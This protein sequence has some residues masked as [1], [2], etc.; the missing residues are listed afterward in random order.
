MAV[1][2]R[3][4]QDKGLRPA[5]AVGVRVTVPLTPL[6]TGRRESGDTSVL[7]FFQAET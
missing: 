5:Q 4:K 6:V 1:I 7:L 3:Y 2:E